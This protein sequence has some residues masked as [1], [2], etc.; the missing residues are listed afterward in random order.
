MRP[1]T[2][3]AYIK[4]CQPPSCQERFYPARPLQNTCDS[5]CALA[6]VR[7]QA[8]QKEEKQRKE[9]RKDKRQY[10]QSDRSYQAKK[11]QEDF[12]RYIVLRDRDDPCISCGRYHKG[13]YHAGHYRSVGSYPELRFNEDNVHKQCDPCNLHL[14]GNSVEYRKGLI[15]KIGAKRLGIL[16][17]PHPAKKYTI[18]DL[19]EIRQIYK[20]KRKDLK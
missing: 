11:A 17:G 8:E 10:L 20:Q 4:K 12:N 7:W 3:K 15:K 1:K 2:C 16:E 14:S 6:L 9:W 19:I 5:R 18:E 13:R